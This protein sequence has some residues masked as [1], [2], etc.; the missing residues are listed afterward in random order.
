MSRPLR[1]LAVQEA[2]P[3]VVGGLERHT[4]TVSREL[5]QR[6]HD[7]AV[8]VSHD[9]D[10][11]D[12]DGA[13]RLLRLPMLATRVPGA[14]YRDHMPFVQHPP[15]PDPLTV[16][17]LRRLVRAE[18]PDVVHARSWM[19]HSLLVATARMTVRPRIVV[20]VHD[21][22]PIC[23][24]RALLRDGTTCAGPRL[25]RCLQCAA[26]DS[27]API[28][29]LKVAG[30]MAG[31]RTMGGVDR[32]LAV[33]EAVRQAI[34]QVVPGGLPAIEV[35]GSTVP[36]TVFGPP[37][38]KV[39]PPIEG[40]YL[41][42]VGSIAPFKGVDVLLDAHARLGP[43]RPALV[44]AGRGALPASPAPAADVHHVGPLT[45]PQ[46]MAAWRGAI[47]GVAP[48]LWPE[49]F[50]QVAV[51][52]MASGVPLVA[53]DTGG[54]RDVVV[55]EHTGLLVAPGDPAALAAAIQ[56]LLDDGEL[57][58]RLQTAGPQRARRYHVSPFVDRLEEIYHEVVEVAGTG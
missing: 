4:Q 55:H 28:G 23:A 19:V 17:A 31:R 48:S 20:S 14:L 36:D 10:Q 27:S 24:T 40:P 43:D 58:A 45:H 18:R 50:G 57:R 11:G 16:R 25:R 33:S 29:V 13:V 22:F 51:E 54:L 3:P 6:G 26:A 35:V 38:R 30:V 12:A 41:L 44:L 1:I 32:W 7:V 21:Y 15:G 46:V 5:A 39:P 34:T 49:P 52:A 56:R 42:F 37:D 53:S 2:Y 8:A 9:G 47:A